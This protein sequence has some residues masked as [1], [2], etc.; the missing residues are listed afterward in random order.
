M[1]SSKM[2]LY[3]WI[4]FMICIGSV[5]IIHIYENNIKQ[6]EETN[7]DKLDK[8]S[9][10]KKVLTYIAMGTT[11]LGVVLYYG[12]KRIE[13]GSR[14]NNLKFIL[15]NPVCKQKSPSAS[16]I[17]KFSAAVGLK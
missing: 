4:F 8:I 6:T 10:A 3:M 12:E 11:L 5:Y 14:F 1:L 7:K 17:E 15:G 13:Y 16:I 9:L 2:D